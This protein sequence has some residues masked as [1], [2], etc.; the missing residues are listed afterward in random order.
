MHLAR[1]VRGRQKEREKVEEK[2]ETPGELARG[3]EN[4]K[5]SVGG[6]LSAFLLSTMGGEALGRHVGYSA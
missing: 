4:R 2:I 3:D 6:K 1:G 5:T